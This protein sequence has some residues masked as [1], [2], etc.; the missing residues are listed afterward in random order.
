MAPR[1]RLIIKLAVLATVSLVV[2]LVLHRCYRHLRG[3]E[4][5]LENVGSQP[6]RSGQVAVRSSISTRTFPV[7]DLT[8]AASACVWVE[9][10]NEAHVDVTFTLPSGALKVIPLHGY[11]EPGYSGWISAEVTSEGARSIK[12]D[13]DFF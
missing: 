8:P 13:I 7:G 5:C 3:I 10:D 4:V 9:A 6:L 12:Q 1:V 2:G 11:I